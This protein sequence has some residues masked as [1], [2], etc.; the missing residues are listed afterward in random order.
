M[1]LWEL[2]YLENYRCALSGACCSD[3]W[4]LPITAEEA[5][6]LSKLANRHP[7]RFSGGQIACEVEEP[8]HSGHFLIHSGVRH[9]LAF[10]HDGQ[11]FI[12][13]TEGAEALPRI[14]RMFPRSRMVTPRGLSQR[15]TPACTEVSRRI[16]RGGGPVAITVNELHDP[17]PPEAE[18]TLG[19]ESTPPI[20]GGNCLTWREMWDLEE[21]WIELCADSGLTA[22]EVLIQVG[23]SLQVPDN[24]AQRPSFIHA[25][26][27]ITRG[28]ARKSL[29]TIPTDAR[30]HCRVMS[31][32]LWRMALNTDTHALVERSR[33]LRGFIERLSGSDEEM[34]TLDPERLHA[35]RAAHLAP[36]ASHTAGIE[37]RYLATYLFA[38]PDMFRDRA[39]AC[40]IFA[41][42]CVQLALVRL[43]AIGHALEEGRPVGDT[44]LQRAIQFVSVHV[45]HDDALWRDLF[46]KGREAK[47]LVPVGLQVLKC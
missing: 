3:Q 17:A 5:E 21:H 2:E 46:G 42:I 34:A 23:I 15:L 29:A 31:E 1:R 40:E 41:R 38:N 45:A 39:D 7:E 20:F 47:Q 43:I 8:P 18:M 10:D 24:P 28:N 9:C 11:C 36:T 35:A 22:E 25:V 33:A 26:H 4:Y 30:G 37:R 13:R 16:V 27:E 14:C 19:G 12:H 32:I 6:R 44:A